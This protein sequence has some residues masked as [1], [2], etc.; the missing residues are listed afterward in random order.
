MAAGLLVNAPVTMAAE[1]LV[2]TSLAKSANA[3]VAIDIVTEG[4]ATA[5]Q[6][7]IALPK[8]VIAEQVDLSRCTADL[9]KHFEGKCSVARGQI[10]GIA[11]NDE[12]KTLPAG[13]VSVGKIGFKGKVNSKMKLK[14]VNFVVS[15]A[16]AKELPVATRISAE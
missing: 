5:I 16:Q 11:Y 2:V 10:I 15:D 7:N 6:F 3:A 1:E 12:G 9:P 14:V 4:S 13:I 8:G